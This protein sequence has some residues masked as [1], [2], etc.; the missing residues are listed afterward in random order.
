MSGVLV[1][2]EARSV[3]RKL[4]EHTSRLAEIDRLEPEAIDHWRHPGS[5]VFDLATYRQLVLL[6]VH[7]PRQVMD[8]ADAPGPAGDIT[9]LA[10]ID[11]APSIL[12]PIAGP[13]VF[14]PEPVESKHSRQ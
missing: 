10:D 5:N 6:V 11:G 3:R 14:A 13:A 9:S 1:S 12:E 7:A 2:S 8:S 4:E